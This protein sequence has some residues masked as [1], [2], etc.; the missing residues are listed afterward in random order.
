MSTEN[1][2]HG[3]FEQSSVAEGQK[4]GFWSM[5]VIMMGFTFFSASMWVG[6]KLGYGLTF[7]DYVWAVMAGNLIL[8]VYCSLLAWQ[9]SRTGLSV[10]LL[11]RYA[12]GTY[13][14]FIPS[15]VL[16]FT[17]IGW[18]GVGVAM[19]SIPATIFFQG[20]PSLAGTWL[21]SGPTWDV[22]GGAGLPVRMLWF[23]TIV[24][25]LLMT[26]SAYFGIRALHIISIIAVPA[27]AVFGL[28]SAIQALFFD[29]PDFI[30]A[31]NEALANQLAASG[32]TLRNGWQAMVSHVPGTNADGSSAAIGMVLAISMGIGSFI[33]GG[34]CTPDFTRFSKNSRT[35]ITTTALAF[36]IG[37]SLMFFFG[38]AAAMVYGKSDISEVL[39]IQGLLVPAIII[40]GLNIWTT[41]DNALYTS[42]LGLANITRLPKRY[43]VLFNG[44]L[45][46]VAAV[47]LYD[48]FCGWLNILNTAI[49]PCGA[50][51][52]VDYF[53]VNKAVYPT[54]EEKKFVPVSCPAVLAWAV[55]FLVALAGFSYIGKDCNACAF[56]RHGIPA[57]NAMIATVVVY[58]AAKLACPCRCKCGCAK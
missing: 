57:I 35:A 21:M 6:V 9:A 22:F 39:V 27:I 30:L 41:N 44:V 49:P 20:V 2:N 58:L 28:W 7:S 52:I 55:G 26:S 16:A 23:L 36:F 53:L 8:G 15:A 32:E 24:S 10:H 1:N 46:T 11:S 47:W 5:F 4:R 51:L 34:T 14:S 56:L 37:N 38:A 31:N 43:I 29:S 54:M 12:F 42:G 33:S 45:G 50:I 13:G 25:G 19:F 3:D 17:Q 18:F 40:L 48:N